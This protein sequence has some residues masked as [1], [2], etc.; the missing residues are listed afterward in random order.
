M[1]QRMLKVAFV[2]YVVD[3]RQPGRS[4]LSDVVWDMAGELARQGHEAHVVA[5]YHTTD[6]PDPRVVVH[7]FPTPPIGYR[8]IVGQVW[9]LNRAA[10]CLRRIQPDIVHAPEYL[11]TALFARLGLPAPLVLTVPG[12]IFQRERAGHGYDWHFVQVLKWAAR[13]SAR[14]CSSVIAISQEMKSWWEWTGSPPERTP[15]IPYGVSPERFQYQAG[16]RARLGLPCDRPLLLY[17]GRFSKEKGLLDLLDALHRARGLAGAAAPQVLLVGSGP[18]EAEIREHVAALGLEPI[19]K[20]RGWVAQGDLKWWYSAADALLMPSWNEPLGR[21]MLEAMSC[22]TP[23]IASATEGPNDHIR[24]AQTGFL[25][26]PRDVARLAEI[27]GQIA[28][29]PALLRQMRAPTLAY[30]QA[31][32]IWPKIVER[33]VDEVYLPIVGARACQNGAS[34]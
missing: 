15:W 24:D 9:I 16:A 29:Q 18:Q 12:N 14:R 21:V 22:G 26:P 6:Y 4:G 27:L 7:N 2:D 31:N 32:L 19:V 34:R 33:I 25:F 13:T 23:V 8:N 5:S 3:P 28:E 10:A 20:V 17:V 11:S 30:A 1:K